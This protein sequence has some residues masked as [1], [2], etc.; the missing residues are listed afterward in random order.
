MKS[1][2]FAL[3]VVGVFVG[4]AAF[5]SEPKTQDV[6][7]QK[8]DKDDLREIIKNDKMLA[9]ME[10][11]PEA[12]FSAVGEGIPPID[13]VS[14]AQAR[15]LAKRS[16]VA[17]AYRQLASKLYG[18]KINAKDTVKDAMLRDSVIETRVTGLIKNA[19]IINQDFKDGLF[20]VEMELKIDK[21]KW[22]ELFAY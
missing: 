16:A 5:T 2:I 21:D 14:P 7:V 1:L 9:G 8:V 3:L 13:T 19:A 12:I 20:R 6:V 18:V 4:C 10:I 15:A 22:Q 17:D 11:N